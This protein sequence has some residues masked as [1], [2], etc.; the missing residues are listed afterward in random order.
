MSEHWNAFTSG[1]ASGDPLV[2]VAFA[3]LAALVAYGLVRR[4]MRVRWLRILLRVSFFGG[5]VALVAVATIFLSYYQWQSW[6]SIVGSILA[7]AFA[8]PALWVLAAAVVATGLALRRPVPPNHGIHIAQQPL[9]ETAKPAEK[10]SET[11]VI[12]GPWRRAA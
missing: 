11:N 3:L 4:L 9:R 8:M 10:Q 6:G 5:V 2:F 7:N 12:E 1:V